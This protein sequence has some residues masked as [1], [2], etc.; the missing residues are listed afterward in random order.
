MARPQGQQCRASDRNTGSVPRQLAIVGSHLGSGHLLCPCTL[1]QP[2]TMSE[3][4]CVH[5]M[6]CGLVMLRQSAP[7]PFPGLDYAGRSRQSDPVGT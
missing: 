4:S 7:R 2:F 5:C 6:Q 3:A 1:Q